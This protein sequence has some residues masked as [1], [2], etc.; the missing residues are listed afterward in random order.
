MN[1]ITNKQIPVFFPPELFIPPKNKNFINQPQQ[2]P[3]QQKPPQ[4]SQSSPQPQQPQQ[5]HKYTNKNL[6]F[7][8]RKL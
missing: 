1:I 7:G 6:Q 3:Q 4:Q 8:L 2:K 5:P